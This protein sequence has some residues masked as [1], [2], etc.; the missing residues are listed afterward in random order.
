MLDLTE[1]N[2]LAYSSKGKLCEQKLYRIEHWANTEIKEKQEV[3]EMKGSQKYW[4]N[5]KNNGLVKEWTF[6]LTLRNF[7]QT[8]RELASPIA[9]LV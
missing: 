4:A 6:L 3:K 9:T 8:V 5:S 7:A 1:P 2:T